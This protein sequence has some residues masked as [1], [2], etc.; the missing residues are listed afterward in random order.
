MIVPVVQAGGI[1]VSSSEEDE[2]INV[3]V[4]PLKSSASATT[5][6]VSGPLEL[7]S[8]PAVP[9]VVLPTSGELNQFSVLESPETSAPGG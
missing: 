7:R 1:S 2:P 9:D 3:T 6:T 4:F 8:R 5:L